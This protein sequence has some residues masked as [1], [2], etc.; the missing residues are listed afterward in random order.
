V[1]GWIAFAGG[2]L[3][4]LSFS[5]MVLGLL[6]LLWLTGAG[7]LKAYLRSDDRALAFRQITT[8]TLG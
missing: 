6:R 5:L 7:I 4:R 1:E 3:F 8:Q 2:P